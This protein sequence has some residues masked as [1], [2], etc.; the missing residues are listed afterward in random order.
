MA[1]YRHVHIEFWKDPKVLEELTPEDKL[2][3]LYLMTNPNT[4]QIGVYKI[5]KKQIAFELGYSI[6]SV[7]AILERFENKHKIIKYNNET[8]EIGIKHWG[9][10]NLK[11]GGKPIMDCIKKELSQVKD[12]ELLEYVKSSIPKPEIVEIFDKVIVGQDIEKVNEIETKGEYKYGT[13][14]K[15]YSKPQPATPSKNE[16]KELYR[17]PTKEELARVKELLGEWEL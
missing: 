12:K 3:F 16:D 14:T 1:I 15:E 6:E 10:Y 5:T 8:R 11:K 13:Y 4:T 7:N 2:M 9:R 17:K